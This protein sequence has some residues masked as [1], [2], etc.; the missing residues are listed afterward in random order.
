MVLIGG[1]VVISVLCHWLTVSSRSISRPLTAIVE[2]CGWT[3]DFTFIRS[4]WF[5]LGG[6]S[7]QPCIY[8]W[9]PTFCSPTYPYLVKYLDRP[10]LLA[11]VRLFP[12]PTLV[13]VKIVPNYRSSTPHKSFISSP[14]P[15]KTES[16]LNSVWEGTIGCC[17]GGG[18]RVWC[19]VIKVH[20]FSS[21]L[22]MDITCDY[23]NSSLKLGSIP[24]NGI[25]HERLSFRST[26]AQI[27]P[28]FLWRLHI[29]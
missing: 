24:T 26:A 21:C 13:F 14:L 28:S 23:A 19:C 25:L 6:S 20:C 11:P 27:L 29:T 4:L 1:A 18:R 5:R 7:E 2:T 16:S 12:A 17:C 22:I 9:A 3:G 8:A 10:R 15:R